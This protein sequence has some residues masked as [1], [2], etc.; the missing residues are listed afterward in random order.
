MMQH[1]SIELLP[2]SQL[3]SYPRNARTHSK[4]QIIAIARSIERFGFNNPVLI[5]E[6]NQIIAGHGRVAAALQLGL[7]EVPT[8]RISHLS[9]ANKRA[10]ILAENRLAEKAGWD[11]EVLGLELGEL[12]GLLM[13]EI[14]ITG[15][16]TGEVDL[17]LSDLDDTPDPADD[18]LA[19]GSGPMVTRTGDLWRLGSHRL[20]C[21]DARDSAAYAHLMAGEQAELVFTDP[22]Y[23]VPIQGHVLGRGA[24]HRE[25]AFASGEMSASEFTA[26]LAEALEHAAKHSVDGSIHY[27]CMDWRHVAE[28]IAAGQVVYT[29]LKNICVWVK[30]NAGQGSFYR[31]QHEFVVVFKSGNA[32]HLNTFELGQHGRTRTNVWTYAGV[33]TFRAGRMDDLAMHPTVKPVSLVADAMRDCSRRKGLVLDPFMGSGTTIMAGEKVGR[34][35]R[36]IECDPAYVDAAIRRWQAF[37]RADAVLAETGQ[38]FEEV[39][40]ARAGAGAGPEAASREARP[41]AMPDTADAAMPA[42]AEDAAEDNDWVRLCRSMKREV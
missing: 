32:P 39:Q 27:V 7:A 34:R 37:T 23:N 18:V 41:A 31:S 29:E 17:L 8:L 11:R 20:I 5:D 26:F 42:N 36:G 10:Y 9:E 38:T 4:K 19:P 28:L 14:D 2:P 13:D 30:T 1:P 3:R 12:S 35:V 33:N 16:E 15:F 6:G 25:F 40:A 21:G 24:R 22:P